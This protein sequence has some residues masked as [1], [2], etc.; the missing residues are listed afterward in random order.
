[1]DTHTIIL[2]LRELFDEQAISKRFEVSKLLFYSKIVEGTSLVH[3]ALK[4]NGY[5]EKP[6]QLGFEM[7]HELSINLILTSLCNSFAPFVLNYMM[8]NIKS[9][10]PKLINMPR[11]VEPSLKSALKSAINILNL[12][13]A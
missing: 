13:R 7:D 9:T 12:E 6:G 4:V 8:N 1:M 2:H 10:I 3:H 11:V 5:I